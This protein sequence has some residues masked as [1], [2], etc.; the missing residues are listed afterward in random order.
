MGLPDGTG[1]F[2]LTAVVPRARLEDGEVVSDVFAAVVRAE[3]GVR[4]CAVLPAQRGYRDEARAEAGPQ[5]RVGASRA[6]DAYLVPALRATP[7]EDLRRILAGEAGDARALQWMM[8]LAG[9]G[10]EAGTAAAK[11][12]GEEEVG[13]EGDWPGHAMCAA[14]DLVV[15]PADEAAAAATAASR[16]EEGEDDPDATTMEG[17]SVGGHGDRFKC[18]ST[19]FFSPA[20]MAAMGVSLPSA[21]VDA[22]RGGAR[23]E[24]AL[25]AHVA[26]RLGGGG[27]ARGTP[28]WRRGQR[29]VRRTAALCELGRRW[30]A[31]DGRPELAAAFGRQRDRIVDGDGFARS[32]IA[33]QLVRKGA[34]VDA[35]GSPS[36]RAGLFDCYAELAASPEVADLLRGGLLSGKGMEDVDAELMALERACRRRHGFTAISMR[37]P[38]PPELGPR[39]NPMREHRLAVLVRAA[40]RLH[41]RARAGG[42]DG[43][44][45][46]DRA[47]AT[48]AAA[49]AYIARAAVA[50]L[51]RAAANWMGPACQDVE[52]VLPAARGAAL[53]GPA[54]REVAKA[55]W[56]ACLKGPAGRAALFGH[57]AEVLDGELFDEDVALVLGRL[58]A[59]SWDGFVE[60]ELG[61]DIAA[62]LEAFSMAQQPEEAGVLG[63][64]LRHAGPWLLG[65][66]SEAQILVAHVEGRKGG[67]DAWDDPAGVPAMLG[68]ELAP[69]D[70]MADV[71]AGR[72][73]VLAAFLDT[74]GAEDRWADFFA[75]AQQEPWEAHAAP[76]SRARPEPLVACWGCG[77]GLAAAAARTCTK[78]HKAS[79]CPGKDCQSRHW[80]QSH[81]IEC[82]LIYLGSNWSPADENENVAPVENV[83]TV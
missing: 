7:P 16:G 60:R 4:G 82:G 6:V 26:A 33:A 45:A 43:G 2:A 42:G 77:G 34:E 69:R 83:A 11:V 62:G 3:G 35:S 57:V 53:G 55:L 41:S 59:R 8:S 21:Y 78:C 79:Y 73:P 68:L 49:A 27:E 40:F 17:F 64:V 75:S 56:R 51:A 18:L 70:S 80:E 58:L 44:V 30:F 20:D 65:I 24:G 36:A 50:E 23:T 48:A 66:P 5:A 81:K 32:A 13:D 9:E 63:E 37:G 76:S 28:G 29:H 10:D 15:E 22:I 46:G 19:W 47:T 39:N 14:G 31:L 61:P 52:A 74:Q 72:H 71:T 1:A 38:P 12:V 54:A 25:L 67:L